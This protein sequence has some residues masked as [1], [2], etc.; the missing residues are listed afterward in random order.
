MRLEMQP[1]RAAQIGF[2]FLRSVWGRGIGTE[3]TRLALAFG[4]DDLGLHRVWAARSPLNE[5]SARLLAKLGMQDEG[6]IRDHI[7]KAGKW[8]DSITSSILEDEWR[9]TMSIG[10]DESQ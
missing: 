8:R 5:A 1:H 7:H 2:A 6:R 10:A 4:F 3:A 9:A